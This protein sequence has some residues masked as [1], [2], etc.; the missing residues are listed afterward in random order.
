MTGHFPGLV[1]ALQY[2]HKGKEKEKS[3]K[4]S[5]SEVAEQVNSL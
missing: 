4:A 5:G 3:T 1:Q 2:M